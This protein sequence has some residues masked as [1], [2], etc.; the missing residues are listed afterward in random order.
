MAQQ[1]QIQ[2]GTPRLCPLH[3]TLTDG[4]YDAGSVRMA[5][6]V[7]HTT[8]GEPTKEEKDFALNR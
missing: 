8:Q 4:L 6:G 2:Q 7:V 1:R 5:R 3:L